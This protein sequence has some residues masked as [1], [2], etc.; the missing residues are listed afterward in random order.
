MKN[1]L[2]TLLLVLVPFLSQAQNGVVTV[3]QDPEITKLLDLYKKINSKTAYYTIQIGFGSYAEATELQDDSSVDFPQFDTK[4]IFD[5]PTY[6]VHLG[7]FKNKLDVERTFAEVR[8]KYPQ[9][10]ILKPIS[11]N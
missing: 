7:R 3:E 9:S 2:Y 10:I 11:N 1:A 4:I 6:R 8:K 5:S